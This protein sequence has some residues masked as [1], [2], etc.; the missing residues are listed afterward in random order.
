MNQ[1]ICIYHANCADGF[2]AAWCVQQSAIGPATHFV[3]ASYGDAP[4]DVTD[5]NVLIVD[6]SYKRAV[7]ERMAE[8]ANCVIVLD[9]HKTAADDL[10]G[11]VEPQPWCAQPTFDGRPPLA[12][13]FDME[14][15]GAQ[16]AW[17]FF[18]RPRARG[19]TGPGIARP[20]LVDYVADRDLWR[21]ELPDS[22]A[23]S[24]WVASFPMTF[25]AWTSLAHQLDDAR[26]FKSAV[27]EGE[28]IARF[29][30]KAVQDAVGASRRDMVIGGYRV[31]VANVPFFFASDGA[32]GM[33]ETAPFAAT[34]YDT[35]GGVRAFSLR[36]R[37]DFDVSEIAK[38]YGGGG[39]K[40][41]AGFAMPLGW[42]GDEETL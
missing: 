38:R 10:R 30:Q 33:A 16:M 3:P 37:G 8:V 12:V 42:E 32:G 39:H 41:A 20:A 4:P 6:F 17:D 27:A 18:M 29:Q 34:Y 14:R 11:F 5:A 2:T 15:S 28:A 9:H 31:P 23:V 1:T 24:T 19:T 26:L 13:E 35:K 25:G 36:S 21:W 7:L 40:N 22:R